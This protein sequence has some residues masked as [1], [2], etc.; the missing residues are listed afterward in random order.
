MT[1]KNNKRPSLVNDAY[2]TPDWVVQLALREIVPLVC[3]IPNSVLEP[4][5]G[6]GAFV[7]QLRQSY[8]HVSITAVDIEPYDWPEANQ[9]IH[10]DFMT[11]QLGRYDL[12]IGNPPFSLAMP[13]INRCLG[14]SRTTVLL[15]RQGFLSSA[16]RNRFFRMHAPS[17][18]F[19][20]PN[21]PCFDGQ[22]TDSADYC[23]A[24]WG[25]A[26]EGTRLFWLPTLPVAQRR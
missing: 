13:F 18:V 6:K 12:A 16:K 23:F 1:T 26:G 22:N 5:A 19:I 24:C 7:R 20:M 10:D 15:L 4:G 3:P 14:C 17:D 21:R 11:T 9:S 8:P 25:R 2:F